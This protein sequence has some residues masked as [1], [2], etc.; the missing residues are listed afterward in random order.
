MIYVDEKKEQTRLFSVCDRRIQSF[1]I[2]VFLL[3][4]N[5]PTWMCFENGNQQEI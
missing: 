1:Q 5:S 4:T 3:S 2:A